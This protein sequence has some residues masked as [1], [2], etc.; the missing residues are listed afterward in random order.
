MEIYTDSNLCIHPILKLYFMQ[1]INTRT[2]MNVSKIIMQNMLTIIVTHIIH[3]YVEI[4]ICLIY[5]MT[6]CFSIYHTFLSQKHFLTWT[7]I[8]YMASKHCP[9]VWH[10]HV[11]QELHVFKWCCYAFRAEQSTEKLHCQNVIQLHKSGSIQPKNCTQV[12]VLKIVT[13]MFSYV[14]FLKIAYLKLWEFRI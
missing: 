11:L 7:R 3:I 2:I 10:L 13:F 8:Q 1:Q 9:F 6:Y 5:S 14:N 4:Y 12:K